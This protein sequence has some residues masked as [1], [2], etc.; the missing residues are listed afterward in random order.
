MYLIPIV[1]QEHGRTNMDEDSFVELKVASQSVS[2]YSQF[3]DML[4]E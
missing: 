3:Y 2:C 1:I 4:L